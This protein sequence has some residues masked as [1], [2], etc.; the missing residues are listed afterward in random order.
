LSE[1]SIVALRVVKEA[2]YLFGSCT[3]VLIMKDLIHAVKHAQSEYAIFLE[4]Q[5]KQALL[6]EEEKKKKE[7]ADEAKRVEQR[8][9]KHLHKQLAELA[10]L[11]TVQMAEQETAIQLISEALKKLC[12]AVQGTGNNLQGAKVAQAMLSAGNEKLTASTKQLADIKHEKEKIEEKLRK[13]ER[14]V[15]NKKTTAGSVVPHTTSDHAA[16]KR[17][18]H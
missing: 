17:K 16:K 3:K 6:E 9:S 4:N 12:E 1:R 13:F 2:I 11:E 14:T 7:Q 15:V 10:Q 8:T 18:L 5:H